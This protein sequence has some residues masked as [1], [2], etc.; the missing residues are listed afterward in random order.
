MMFTTQA[1]LW[2]GLCVSDPVGD[3][4]LIRC[5]NARLSSV[6]KSWETSAL[7]SCLK[8]EMT[9]DGAALTLCI[10]WLKGL[11]FFFSFLCGVEELKEKAWGSHPS[12]HPRPISL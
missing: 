12:S 5:A 6:F 3:A 7:L 4:P 8:A 1:E 10:L 11:F 2:L 9:H